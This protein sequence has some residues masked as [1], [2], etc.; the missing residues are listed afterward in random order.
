MAG[1]V[2]FNVEGAKPQDV[3]SWLARRDLIIRYVET[4]PCTSSARASIGWWDTEEEV[5]GLAA[6][7]AELAEETP[8]HGGE[9]L[10]RR[11]SAGRG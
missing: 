9:R 5:A 2:N 8:P 10:G 11:A 3:A 7:I 4:K 6:S 1:L